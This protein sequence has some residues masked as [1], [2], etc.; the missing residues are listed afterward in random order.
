MSDASDKRAGPTEPSD[1]ES[2]PEP[3]VAADAEPEPKPAVPAEPEPKPAV[4]AEPEPKPEPVAESWRPQRI[5]GTKMAYAFALLTGVLYF[6]GYPGMDLWPVSLVALAPLIVALRGQSVRRATG[7]GWLSGFTMTMVGFYWLLGML[8]TFSGFPTVLCALFMALLCGYQAGRIA[9]CGFIYGR[10]ASRGWPASLC[11][12]GAFAASELLYP[13]IFPWDFGASVHNAPVFLQTADL[14][15]PILV[16][17]VLV[18]ANLAVA[19][20]LGMLVLGARVNRRLLV[21]G[22]V[23]PIVAALYGQWRISSIDAQ[24]ERSEAVKVGLV[25]GNSPLLGRQDAL[26]THLKLTRQLK[27]Q[28]AQ[29]VVWSEASVTGA[30]PEKDMDKLMRRA[31]T[32]RLGVPTIIGTVLHR[33]IEN[34]PPK[35]RQAQLFNTA[36]LADEKGN[37]TSRYDKHILLMFGEYIPFGETF[38]KLY[39]WSPNSG[40][41]TPGTSF[42]PL[43]LGSHR[44]A[45]TICYEDI[46][47]SFVRQG[48]RQDETDML[49]NL[50]NDTWFGDTTEP[51]I[52][53]A[54]AKM[55]SV[56]HR[57]YL[58]RATNSGVSAIIDPAGRV[59][60]HSS[61]G[62]EDTVLGTAHYMRAWTVYAAIGNAPWWLLTAVMAAA[63]VVRKP[64]RQAKGAAKQEPKA[65]A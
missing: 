60:A 50:T 24:I 65:A 9:L 1:D 61:V 49:V 5:L 7:L 15:G 20:L 46:I 42:E 14:G 28:G 63:C 32:S 64:R 21:A 25:Q 52:H 33:P 30:F 18:A 48:V 31:F 53:L 58:L 62:K 36:V 27:D 38:P 22:A 17:L 41:F 2:K 43:Q 35:G 45:T 57:R 4:P 34:A 39:E 47:P 37:I 54:Q 11:F 40:G 23:V 19:E 44:F 55:R 8:K 10:A 13:L 6:L 12:V 51:W 3:A 56:E 59:V 26:R 16:G 29:L